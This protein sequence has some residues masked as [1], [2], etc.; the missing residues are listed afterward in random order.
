MKCFLCPAVALALAWP[1]ASVA[2]PAT[3]PIAEAAPEFSQAVAPREW[4]FPR[5]HGRHDSFKTEWWYFTGNLRDDAK[6]EFGYQLTFF[7]TAVAPVTPRRP[8][9]WAF[10]DLYFAHAAITDVAGQTFVFKDRLSRGRAGL[11]ESSDTTLDVRL[12]DWKAILDRGAIRLQA[13]EDSFSIDLSCAGG[14][15]PVLQGPGGIN[16]KGRR[17]EQASYYYSMTRLKTTGTLTL[18]GKQFHVHG[19]TWMDHEF[20][21]NA[22][23]ADQTG[24]DWFGLSLADGND[25]MIYRLRNRA[26]DADF[27]SGTIIQPDGTPR[28]LSARDISLRPSKPWVSPAS[29]SAYP[30]EW[31]VSVRGMSQLTVRTRI[32]GQELITTA[33][34][35][36][37][38]FEGS[39]DVLNSTGS[40]IGEGYLEM[41][42]YGRNG[43]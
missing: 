42:G 4:A 20:S 38:Y 24:W 31:A 3:Q 25:L 43:L 37:D 14:R 8:S 15:G 13:N 32:P 28:Y 11:A 27:L 17:P 10:H 7:R 1:A 12:L 22:L 35:K 34:T 33:S 39:A 16:A 5:D 23:S 29:G 30:Q 2:A 36:V 9:P 18:G 40:M 26:G 6:R 21:S 19:D 41:T